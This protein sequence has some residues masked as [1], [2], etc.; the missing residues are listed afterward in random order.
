MSTTVQGA[1]GKVEFRHSIRGKLWLAFGVTV[2]LTGCA[3]L[4]GI[5][6]YREIGQRLATIA[7]E[8]LPAISEVRGLAEL[9]TA[10]AAAGPSL[11]AASDEAR[12][13]AAFEAIGAR[14]GT[15][16]AALRDVE[17]RLK[18][19]AQVAELDGKARAV[20]AN[21]D[22]LNAAVGE[23]LVAAAEKERALARLLETHARV[24][25]TLTPLREAAQERL[26]SESGKL[27][28]DTGAALRALTG[29]A[30]G[31][32][33]DLYEL[34]RAVAAAAGSAAAAVQ[35]P[36]RELD[37]LWQG[38]VNA[39]MDVQNRGGAVL[40]RTGEATLEPLLQGLWTVGAE[41]TGVFDTRRRA[42]GSPADG[43]A[44]R[45]AAELG[46]EAARL[47]GEIE[48]A[49]EPLIVAART[50]ILLSGRR[51]EGNTAS[52]VATFLEQGVDPLTVYLE[53]SAHSNA[54]NGILSEGAAAPDTQRLAI[55]AGNA[56]TGLAGLRN[57]A[58]KAPEADRAG[59][60][61]AVDAYAAL[62]EG[63]A[64]LP[65]LR[66]TEL[67]LQ[68][69]AERLLEQ[70]RQLA[71]V[72]G[73]VVADLVAREQARADAAAAASHR[74]IS[75]GQA[76]L[77]AIVAVSVAAGLL[78]GW[79]Y[80]GRIVAARLSA[81]A[82]AMRRVAAGDLDMPIQV[83]GR[84]EIATMTSALLV[85]RDAT[86][87]VAEASAQAD[88]QRDTAAAER[89]AMLS[90]LADE[91]EATV[92]AV[93]ARVLDS[94]TTLRGAAGNMADNAG[95]TQQDAADA[96]AAGHRTSANVQA[97]AASTEELNASITEIGRRMADSV[98]LVGGTVEAVTEADSTV[99]QL[100][101]AA[102]RIGQIVTMIEEVASQ[103][104]LLA[105]NA[106]IEAARAGEAGKGFAVVASEVKTLATQTARAT[107][108]I[109]GQIASVQEI[110]RRTVA[111]L[112]AISRTVTEVNAVTVA[113]SG[114]I[115]EQQA[116]TQEIARNIAEAAQG[117]GMV[118]HSIET[119]GH[120]ATETGGA[121]GRVL[122]AAE[123]LFTEAESMHG[124][125]GGFL[126]N[127][128]SA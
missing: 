10:V 37:G 25:A 115:E 71:E 101:E 66:G 116:A 26:K 33:I 87:A 107:E 109:S 78:I 39:M 81:L 50:G 67:R 86:R 128:R 93:V 94:A 14:T 45:R 98:R 22:R 58:G 124:H 55:L 52:S 27:T 118:L 62:A 56:T 88:R 7:G 21:L 74:A 6:S 68:A 54:L 80:V 83:A 4:V 29:E 41:G 65:G 8:S 99:R 73:A 70:N 90:R 12:R 30:I 47:A 75:G 42:V 123:Q 120:A 76:L 79:L 17:A 59:I 82:E 48:A 97:V 64:S 15:L 127:V 102:A 114:A 9:S 121:A 53:L 96:S 72:L 89:R 63:P 95:R 61:A 117:A 113:V 35:A 103:T 69:E 111:A 92:Q 2:A 38:Y 112:Q 19:D 108:E 126:A 119:V 1:A 106:T 3:G 60:L 11:A 16:L 57:L 23:R 122:G 46:A 49:I 5:L 40:A 43:A 44:A 34:R 85:F 77:A 36:A 100:D 84:D 31:G 20:I 104:S 110:S 18:A 91:F 28:E 13:Q 32:L 125:V 105:L 24:A 51:L